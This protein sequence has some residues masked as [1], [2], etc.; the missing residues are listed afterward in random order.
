MGTGVKK[1][2]TKKD[3]MSLLYFKIS[4]IMLNHGGKQARA[5]SPSSSSSSTSLG[6]KRAWGGVWAPVPKKQS[7]KKME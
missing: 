1:T 7:P 6:P 5:S 2:N 4:S 3:G